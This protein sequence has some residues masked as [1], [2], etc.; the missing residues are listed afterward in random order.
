MQLFEQSADEQEDEVDD[1]KTKKA[2]STHSPQSS[3]SSSSSSVLST[4]KRPFVPINGKSSSKK[5]KLEDLTKMT[6][7]TIAGIK[8][9]R[10]RDAM[11][12]ILSC[13]E[14]EN[15]KRRY[16]EMQLISLMSNGQAQQPF[17][18][19]ILHQ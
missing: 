1:S 4:K 14:K 18:G 8:E 11:G 13:F 7:D 19:Q 15:E 2:R 9:Q 17:Q 6:S 3:T 10:Q 5:E 16:C 12:P